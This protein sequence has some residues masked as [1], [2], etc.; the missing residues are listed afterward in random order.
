MAYSVDLFAYL[1]LDIHRKLVIL[2]PVLEPV[3]KPGHCHNDLT[4]QIKQS[5]R[6]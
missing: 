4:L 5:K 6:S 2:E 3:L 1:F